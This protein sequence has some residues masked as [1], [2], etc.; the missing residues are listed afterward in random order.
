MTITLRAD[1]L[2]KT[3]TRKIRKAGFGAAVRG[4]FSRGQEE[5]LHAVSELGFAIERGERVG[6]IGENGAGKS[7][8]LKMLTGILVPSSGKLEVLGL[9]PWRQRRQLAGQ[10]GVVFGQRPQL[11]WDIPVSETFSLL[12][13]MY[14]IPKAVYD[15]TY[16]HGA[17]G[18]AS[19]KAPAPSRDSRR[20][21]DRSQ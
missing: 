5:S 20:G 18:C 21:V 9:N 8:T 7:T 15:V 2:C 3:Y 14:R 13:T 19:T 17:R 16:Q 6:L 10:I 1:A 11:L 12:R 4:L